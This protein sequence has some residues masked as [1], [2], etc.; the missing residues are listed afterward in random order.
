MGV[1]YILLCGRKVYA[2]IKN[3]R[4]IKTELTFF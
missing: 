2:T 3:R 4:D 1:M